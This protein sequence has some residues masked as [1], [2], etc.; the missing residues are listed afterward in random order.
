[1]ADQTRSG[2]GSVGRTDIAIAETPVAAPNA[3]T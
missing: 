1:M 3:E 2:C